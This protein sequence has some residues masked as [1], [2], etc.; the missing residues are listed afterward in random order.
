M[1]LAAIAALAVVYVVVPVM[2][3]AF[4]HFRRRRTVRCPETGLMASVS[5]AA[6]R[7]ALTAVP[8]PPTLKVAD[9]SLWPEH[10]GCEERCVA[11]G[12]GG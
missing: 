8:G 1:I 6:G 3:D 2:I 7:A 9:C 4:L 12:I 10:Q 11:H 5:I